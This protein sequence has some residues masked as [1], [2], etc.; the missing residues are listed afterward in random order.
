MTKFLQSYNDGVFAEFVDHFKQFNGKSLLIFN[1]RD[2]ETVAE[3]NKI[4]I[5]TGTLLFRVLNPE[6]GMDI[7]VQSG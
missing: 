3:R 1:Q 6:I 5:E 7:D 2:F 4:P